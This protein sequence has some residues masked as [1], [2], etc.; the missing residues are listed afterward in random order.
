MKWSSFKSFAANNYELG[1]IVDRHIGP[2]FG[3]DT[4]SAKRKW[5]EDRVLRVRALPWDS[6][7]FDMRG[8]S[9]SWGKLELWVHFHIKNEEPRAIRL[10]SS[11]DLRPEASLR[12]L[13]EELQQW[14]SKGWGRPAGECPKW[15]THPGYHPMVVEAVVFHVE[16]WQPGGISIQSLDFFIPPKGTTL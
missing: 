2:P 12:E 11:S 13:I 15:V 7:N 9:W 4:L 8:F 6:L 1:H 16:D 10:K 5:V 14:H 3:F